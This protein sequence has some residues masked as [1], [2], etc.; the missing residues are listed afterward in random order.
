MNVLFT[1]FFLPEFKASQT[2][3]RAWRLKKIQ[4][5][6]FLRNFFHDLNIK[7]IEEDMFT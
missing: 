5:K 2:N 7:N 3:F 4:L 1:S 6:R